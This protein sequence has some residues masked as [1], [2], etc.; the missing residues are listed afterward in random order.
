MNIDEFGKWSPYNNDNPKYS[1]DEYNRSFI[2]ERFECPQEFE[3]SDYDEYYSVPKMSDSFD[4]Q[5][6]K[7]EKSGQKSKNTK[8][9][10]QNMISKVVCLAAGSVIITTSYQSVI[11]QQQQAPQPD[12]LPPYKQ[13]QDIPAEDEQTDLSPNWNWSEDKK[14]VIL[15]LC[16]A[17]GNVIKEIPAVVSVSDV[18]ATCN[19]E[20]ERTYTANVEYE[21]NEYSNSQ[22][23]T[24]PPLGHDFGEGSSEVLENGET[25]MTFECERCHEQF[26][27]KTFMTEND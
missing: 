15:E 27:F 21:G 6:K 2:K 4:F 8:Q 1:G 20:G 24:L 7:K 14:T 12:V 25:I 10:R 17:D 5:K 19:K 26:T 3:G 22:S 11:K 16:D 13:T 9:L 23:E 18:E